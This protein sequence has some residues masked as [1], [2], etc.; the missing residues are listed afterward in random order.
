M[1]LFALADFSYRKRLGQVLP[2]LDKIAGKVK[3]YHV[4]IRAVSFLS[5]ENLRLHT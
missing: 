1:K 4:H 5:K 2:T 3:S